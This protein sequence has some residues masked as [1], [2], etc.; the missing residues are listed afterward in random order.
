MA[1]ILKQPNKDSWLNAKIEVI[2]QESFDELHGYIKT[3]NKPKLLTALEQIILAL[4]DA[5]QDYQTSIF[6]SMYKTKHNYL[7][8][9]YSTEYTTKKSRVSYEE[10]EHLEKYGKILEKINPHA[11]VLK[12]LKFLDVEE[13][14]FKEA[15]Y[16][17]YEIHKYFTKPSWYQNGK[18][19][20]ELE[21]NDIES[22][23]TQAE[24]YAI[25]FDDG[26][27]DS[28]G[29]TNAHLSDARLFSSVEVAKRSRAQRG[30]DATIVKVSTQLEE[31]IIGQNETTDKIM[32]TIEKRRLEKML[33]LANIE[34]LKKQIAEYEKAN[35]VQKNTTV[36]PK[37]KLKV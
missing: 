23:I 5:K 34:E 25:L 13:K 4:Q 32:A 1:F 21:S 12:A 37:K 28:N 14:K 35:G 11:K 16:V 9:F 17:L 8:E 20:G 36:A 2:T 26:Y 3:L 27:L 6:K 31:V 22:K 18:L 19:E 10:L 7:Y 15:H 29:Y 24:S 33:E 30:E